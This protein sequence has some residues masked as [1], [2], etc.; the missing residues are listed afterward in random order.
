[1]KEQ[2]RVKLHNLNVKIDELL[3]RKYKHLRRIAP[4]FTALSDEEISVYIEYYE[5]VLE[6]VHHSN[7]I[8]A[9]SGQ[10]L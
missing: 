1:M 2:L 9:V 10:V 6:E 5:E 4:F 8:L 3:S 7:L